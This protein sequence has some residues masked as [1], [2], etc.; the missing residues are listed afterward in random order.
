[1]VK[2]ASKASNLL[3]E[4]LKFLTIIMLAIALAS[5][6][7]KDELASLDEHEGYEIVLALDASESML[8]DG[9]FDATKKI[10]SDFIDER[11][12]DKIALTIYAS[13]SYVAIPLT[14]DKDSVKR[15]L[16]LVQIGIAGKQ[17]ALYEA[18]FISANLFKESK[19]K[20]KVIIL[21]TDGIN[22]IS[23]IPL[24][25]AVKTAV[26]YNA[27]VYTIGIG[28]GRNLNPEVLQEI[29]TQTGGRYYHA[30]DFM[31]L[32]SIYK[33]IDKLEKSKLE[34]QDY[35]KTNYYFLVPALFA[36]FFLTL[37]FILYNRR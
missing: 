17:T 26:K 5:P 27:K 22:N 16:D 12:N 28:N 4:T 2:S 25:V 34:S 37:Y 18:L 3:L 15:V 11:K 29:A 6:V 24:D 30:D 31:T 14:Y 1:M 33:Q 23:T 19:T 7:K 9:K 20:D 8:I 35:I 21:P 13:F 32:S 10:L 36:L